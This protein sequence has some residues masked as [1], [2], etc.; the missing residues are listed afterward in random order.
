M[1]FFAVTTVTV[2]LLYVFITM[3]HER[4]KAVRIFGHG[5]ADLCKPKILEGRMVEMGSEE[6][7]TGKDVPVGEKALRNDLWSIPVKQETRDL[8][9]M[10]FLGLAHAVSLEVACLGICGLLSGRAVR[11]RSALQGTTQGASVPTWD[12]MLSAIRLD[13]AS[14][15]VESRP[16]ISNRALGSV[17]E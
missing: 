8:S 16:S 14:S 3:N 1:D 6:S 4:R 7:I 9:R 2:R 13:Q 12:L 15:T 5:G 17:P 11:V 10:V